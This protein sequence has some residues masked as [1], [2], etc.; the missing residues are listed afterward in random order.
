LDPTG[1]PSSALLRAQ[2]PPTSTTPQGSQLAPTGVLSSALLHAQSPPTS[3]TPQ[4]QSPPIGS[5]PKPAGRAQ[6]H[7]K[8]EVTTVTTHSASRPKKKGTPQGSPPPITS[9]DN[10]YMV[11]AV[12]EADFHAWRDKWSDKHLSDMLEKREEI[13]HKMAKSEKKLSKLEAKLQTEPA[14]EESKHHATDQMEAAKLRTDLAKLAEKC[15]FL[16]DQMAAT[17]A[18]GT[19]MTKSEVREAELER[20]NHRGGIIQS[21]HAKGKGK[22]KGKR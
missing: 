18:R 19:D 8:V 10:R 2:S 14:T 1:F 7:P 3:T 17:R 22:G 20:Q 21:P 6:I 15:R 4:G 9:D 12:T 13:A 11:A 5:R 16:E